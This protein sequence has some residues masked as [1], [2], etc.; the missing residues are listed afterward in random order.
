MAIRLKTLRTAFADE[1][2]DTKRRDLFVR[3]IWELL[4]E[5]GQEQDA[6]LPLW[7]SDEDDLGPALLRVAFHDPDSAAAIAARN[8]GEVDIHW[9]YA[10]GSA[11]CAGVWLS[12]PDFD[13]VADEWT[14]SEFFN[15]D[16]WLECY[17][18]GTQS[19]AS[20]DGGC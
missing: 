15:T 9:F 13:G 1:V 7:L 10:T 5:L 20:D 16:R 11:V 18:L 17:R 3:I 8:Y 19:D 12:V 6:W 4:R 2:A 14:Y